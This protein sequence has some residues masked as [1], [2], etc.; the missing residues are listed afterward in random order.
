MPGIKIGLNT[1]TIVSQLKKN[2]IK[3]PTFTIFFQSRLPHLK[4]SIYFFLR[5]ICLILLCLL[6]CV[7]FRFSISLIILF[8]N[9]ILYRQKKKNQRISNRTVPVGTITITLLRYCTQYIKI[10][11]AM[12][13]NVLSS[14]G[15]PPPEPLLTN[16]LSL[17]TPL[18][19]MP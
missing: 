10:A 14:S 19:T 12:I 16:I 5:C 9:L 18:Y 11:V 7:L 17:D 15:L 6:V 8:Q 2:L 3:R 4:T 1:A 13:K